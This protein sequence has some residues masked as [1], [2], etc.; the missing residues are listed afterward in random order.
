MSGES[1]NS[2]EMRYVEHFEKEFCKKNERIENGVENGR[3]REVL[4]GEILIKAIS[5]LV[6][7]VECLRIPNLSCEEA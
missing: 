2:L 1:F 7:V 4:R 3:K 5:M 6:S